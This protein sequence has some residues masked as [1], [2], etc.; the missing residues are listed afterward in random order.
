M[1]LMSCFD[2]WG[3]GMTDCERRV[4]RLIEDL[5]F[6]EQEARFAVALANGETT[7][8]VRAISLP[9]PEN[10][11][12]RQATLLVEHLGFTPDEAARFVAGDRTAIE[13]V[14]AR[15]VAAD[16]G[17]NRRDPIERIGT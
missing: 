4:T 9:L 5:G 16:V 14:A 7:G 10:E 13:A 6:D 2:V 12:S 8:C 3:D 15:R 1:P 11:A 17:T